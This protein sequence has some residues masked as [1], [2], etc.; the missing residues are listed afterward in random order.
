MPLLSRI[1]RALRA[2]HVV[3]P[4]GGFLILS[5][6][7]LWRRFAG[8]EPSYT[9]LTLLFAG[10]FAAVVRAWPEAA[11]RADPFRAEAPALAALAGAAG[12]LG[13]GADRWVHAMLWQPL[14]AARG[15][16]LVVVDAAVR[17]LLSG[18]DPYRVYHVP[19]EAPL[20]YGPVLWAPHLAA[21][22]LDAD[23]R[24]VTVAGTMFVAL[25]CGGAAV[26]AAGRGRA[27]EAGAW[28]LLLAAIVLNPDLRTF[29]P[30]GHTPAYWPLIPL[31]AFVVSAARWRAA[32]IVLALLVAGRT[33][34]AAIVPIF[35]MAVWWKRRAE[36]GPAAMAFALTLAAVVAPF[37]VWD[38][39][40]MWNG[41]VASY[42]RV[43]KEVVW[44]SPDRAVT[45]TIGI[46]GWLLAHRLG[47]FVEAAQ[48]SLLA[49]V[50][51][52]AWR[53]IGRR[54]AQPL[55]W[56]ALGLLAFSATTLWPVYY[57]YFDV[58]LL[59]AAA[60]LV[61]TV[62]LGDRLSSIARAWVAA[63]VVSVV[64]VSA[65][66]ALEA[67]ALPSASFEAASRHLYEGF[68][69]GRDQL[70]G[71]A[72]IWGTRATLVL[73]RRSTAG[74]A[75]V[76]EVRPVIAEDG[77]PQAITGI[78]NGRLLGTVTARAGWREIRFD[79]PASA[80]RIGSNR[81][82]IECSSSSPPR[83]VGLGSEARHI[84]L[85]IR[86]VGVRPR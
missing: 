4:A 57:I 39:A 70:A 22:M 2:W 76:M 29:V 85:A 50:Y 58:L 15:D 26:F 30:V 20:P 31:F 33:T 75:I 34:M 25:C 19:W 63:L 62:D 46:T 82:D 59:F 6:P 56:M 84:A 23:P 78:L 13:L 48:I 66:L 77:P 53:A 14:D 69:P 44:T 24:L 1:D 67:P 40:A 36:V 47:G 18:H 17:T 16:M 38:P 43:M 28:L 11:D 61:T 65:M 72:A 3:A 51:V 81:L 12:L 9:A 42:P 8:G 80:W 71:G 10:L 86:R 41:M 79:A 32:A 7:S 21:R 60:A 68:V 55:P 49:A 37:A 5:G 74:A 83:E 35:F 54:S 45:R 52:A 64:A 73:P 27:R